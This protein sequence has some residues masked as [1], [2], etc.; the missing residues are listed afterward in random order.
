MP[1]DIKEERRGYAFIMF[2]LIIFFVAWTVFIYVAARERG[3]VAACEDLYRGELKFDLVT[4]PD[5]TREWKRVE[6]EERRGKR[7]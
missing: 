7:E 6:K 3:Y 5:G 1:R 4:N 2:A